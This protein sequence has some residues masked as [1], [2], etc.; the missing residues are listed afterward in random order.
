MNILSVIAFVIIS[1]VLVVA[2]RKY[3][4]D[5]ALA[6]SICAGVILMT[7]IILEASPVF[8]QIRSVLGTVGMGGEYGSIIFKALGICFLTQ[9]A[10]DACKDAGEK[11]LGSRI[12]FAGKIALLVISLPLFENIL[13]ITDSLISGS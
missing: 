11:S 1:L 5:I 8:D 12:E 2:I 13:T 3:S 4:P 6:V 9:F 10:S 7:I